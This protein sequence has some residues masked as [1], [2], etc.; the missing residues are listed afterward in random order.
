VCQPS[1]RRGR[2]APAGDELAGAGGDGAAEVVVGPGRGGLA[3]ALEARD[4][5]GGGVVAEVVGQV[6]AGGGDGEGGEAAGGVVAA[7]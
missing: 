4:E 1:E 2:V 6:A 5:A 7:A 3:V